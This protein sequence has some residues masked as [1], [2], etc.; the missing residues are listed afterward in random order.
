METSLKPKLMYVRKLKGRMM[1]REFP[2]RDRMYR[3]VQ[4]AERGLHD[5]LMEIE[6]LMSYRAPPPDPFS[7]R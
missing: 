5:L 4:L 7:R 1:Q 2:D 3:D 6:T